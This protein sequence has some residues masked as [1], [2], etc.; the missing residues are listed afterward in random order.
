[1][2]GLTVEKLGKKFGREWVF[3]DFSYHFSIGTAYAVTGRNGTGKS[4]MLKMLAGMLLPDEG[5]VT[6]R[7]DGTDIPHDAVYRKIAFAAPYGGLAEELTLQ[8][9]MDFVAGFRPFVAD[10]ASCIRDMGLEHAAGRPVK[11]FSSG[12]RQKVRLALAFYSPAPIL[13]LDEPTSNLDAANTDWYF[14]QVE[15]HSKGR[16]LV[17][18][19]NLPHEY[20]F[21]SETVSLSPKH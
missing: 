2:T 15:K 14:A 8:E 20:A 16:L 13:L 4:T 21:A 18:S 7:L 11:Q 6:C 19:S 10:I 3:C 12:M 5:A 9:L 1:M 17:V